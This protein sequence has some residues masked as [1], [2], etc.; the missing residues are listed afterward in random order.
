MM[1]VAIGAGL[2]V[3]VGATLLLSQWGRL[4]RP[5]LVER[6]RP[7]SPGGGGTPR[8]GGLFSVESLRDVV[9]PLARECGDRV[10]ALFGVT[11]PLA[12][13]LRRV[14]WRLGVTE[15]RLRQ[16]AVAGIALLAG[17]VVASV[18]LPGPVA[19]LV[20]A[21]AP[22]LAFL[23]TEQRL[24]R[25]SE[26]W[27]RDLGLELPVVSEQLATL[28]NAGYSLGA[29]L[30]RV[31]QRGRGCAARDLA[32]VVNRI[33][34][35]LSET[36]ALRE[37]A[38]LARVDAVDRLVGVLALHSESADLGR[39]VS[40]EA[41]QARRDLHRRTIEAIERRGQ[42]VW[43]PVTVATLVPGVILLAVPF[44]SALH[45]FANA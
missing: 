12:L 44:L 7:F 20:V 34:Q 3:W 19:I 17:A 23:V 2:L 32:I 21:G 43:V 29:A 18:G 13:R 24:A 37:W 10:A 22:L 45:L 35:G 8:A 14:H 25:A 40:A 11:E 31:S 39:L 36:D 30:A 5:G 27:Q 42:Q 28:L 9:G 26:R 6:L 15:F 33:R 1:R 16:L 41:R 4:A 38:D